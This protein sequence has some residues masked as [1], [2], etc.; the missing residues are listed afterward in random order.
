MS[1][2]QPLNTADVAC[3]KE[4]LRRVEDN[5]DYIENQSRRNNVRIDGVPEEANETWGK[6][7]EMVKQQMTKTFSMKMKCES[8]TLI[9]NQSLTTGIFPNKLKSAKVIPLF[10]KGDIIYI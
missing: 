10:K 2:N 5:I 6:T 7:E 9:I 3:M 1:K 4:Q 8:V